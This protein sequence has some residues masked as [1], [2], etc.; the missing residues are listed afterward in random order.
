M[1]NKSFTQ[2]PI[3][4]DDKSSMRLFYSSIVQ[5]IDELSGN[6]NEDF[7]TTWHVD[8]NTFNKITKSVSIVKED[9]ETLSFPNY[10]EGNVIV[11]INKSSSDITLVADRFINGDNIIHANNACIFIAGDSTWNRII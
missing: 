2:I 6:R 7:L 4:L 3:N 11:V 8:N 1:A 9:Q 10:K 5:K